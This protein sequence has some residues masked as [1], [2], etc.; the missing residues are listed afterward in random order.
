[1]EISVIICTYNRAASLQQALSSLSR[2][3]VPKDLPWEIVVVDNNSSD[4]TK[5][6]TLRFAESADSSIRVQYVFEGRQGLN[7][8]RNAGIAAAAGDLLFYIDDDV[9]VTSNWLTEMKNAFDLYPIIGVGG[10]VLLKTD[11]QR[12]TWWRNEYDGALGK[13]DAG[14]STI[15]SDQSYTS[16]IG[17][18]ANLGFKKSAFKKHGLFHPH[19]DRRKN[20][21]GMGGD[22]EFVQ[23]AKDGGDLSMYYPGAVVYHCPVATRIT[24]SYLRRWYFRIGEWQALKFS[25]NTN[26]SPLLFTVPRWRYG[27]VLS[28]SW[29]T[30]TSVFTGRSDTGFYHELQLI[31]ALGYFFGAMKRV[32]L[33]THL[34]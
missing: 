4:N 20:K 3:Q 23:R 33:R 18:G 1:M 15:L 32:I 31:S 7:H 28:Q 27:Q 13:F 24:K 12:P 8:A 10:K 11:L 5:N 21:V 26:T 2:M 25:T 30:L 29:Q 17:I 34:K 22:V 19:L 9:E 6:V 14:D 16:I